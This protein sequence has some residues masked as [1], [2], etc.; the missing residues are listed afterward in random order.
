MNK[1][2]RWY[3]F[4]PISLERQR[5]RLLLGIAFFS[6]IIAAFLA[7]ALMGLNRHIT[8]MTSLV[9][10]PTLVIF[11]VQWARVRTEI[12]KH[13]PDQLEER[14]LASGKLLAIAIGALI[15]AVAIGGILVLGIIRQNPVCT[16]QTYNSKNCR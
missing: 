9:I 15:V 1:Y 7:V 13:G 6:I 2:A 10:W 5:R 3:P 14:V 11:I 12:S 8:L 4:L 16:P